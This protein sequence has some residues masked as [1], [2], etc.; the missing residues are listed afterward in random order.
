MVSINS[1][2]QEEHIMTEGGEFWEVVLLRVCEDFCAC[3]GFV[4][5]FFL[6]FFNVKAKIKLEGDC[7][8][9]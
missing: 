6:S 7:Y 2:L 1:G 9:I 8:K 3:I 5:F 4:C